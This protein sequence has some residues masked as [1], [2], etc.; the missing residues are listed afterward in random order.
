MFV[1]L[2]RLTPPCA[3]QPLLLA[4]QQWSP[5]HET[6]EHLVS[7]RKQSSTQP[8]C[9]LHTEHVYTQYM[10]MY[11]YMYVYIYMYVCMLIYSWH[12]PIFRSTV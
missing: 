6:S 1:V 8:S 11:M 3:A 9:N 4:T 7:K 10:Y 2:P 12:C 5:E